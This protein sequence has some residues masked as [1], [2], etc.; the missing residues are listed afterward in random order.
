MSLW[1]HIQAKDMPEKFE[2]GSEMDLRQQGDL[3]C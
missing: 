2:G 3:Q 1:S